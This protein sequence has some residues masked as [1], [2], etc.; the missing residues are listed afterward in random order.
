MTPPDSL[1]VERPSDA[2]VVFRLNRPQVRNALNLEVRAR[3]ADEVTRHA[4]NE[5]IR[6]LIALATDMSGEYL[7]QPGNQRSRQA[8]NISTSHSRYCQLRWPLRCSAQCRR[9]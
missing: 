8:S 7:D 5:K 1:L 2:I 4:A 6:C 9:T 3:L